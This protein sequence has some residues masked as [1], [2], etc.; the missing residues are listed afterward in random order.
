ME[1]M[2]QVFYHATFQA[3]PQFPLLQNRPCDAVRDDPRLSGTRVTVALGQQVGK[4][5]LG[6]SE[7]GKQKDL[8]TWLPGRRQDA[9]HL[10]PHPVHLS[11][12]MHI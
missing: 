2:T 12:W 11:L 7:D 9:G 5:S 1:T 3:L 10:W 4:P 8:L 6:I